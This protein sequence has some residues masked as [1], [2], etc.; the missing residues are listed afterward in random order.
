MTEEKFPLMVLTN[1]IHDPFIYQ[2]WKA[3]QLNVLVCGHD[4]NMH[5]KFREIAGK[6]GGIILVDDLCYLERSFKAAA[7]SAKRFSD[8][9][10]ESSKAIEADIVAMKAEPIRH[11]Q[12]ETKRAFLE[13]KHKYNRRK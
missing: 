3:H 6:S 5:D 13:R 9:L 2:R 1:P 7:D 12:A 4:Q 11:K 8:A 10:T